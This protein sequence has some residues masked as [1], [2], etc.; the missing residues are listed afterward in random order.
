MPIAIPTAAPHGRDAGAPERELEDDRLPEHDAAPTRRTIRAAVFGFQGLGNLGDEMIL[1]GIEQ[2]LA[3]LPIRV[4]TLF[5]G[6]RLA[7]TPAYR[8][9]SRHTTW[10]LL[11]TP[12]AMRVLARHD[13]FMV[14]GGGLINDYWPGLIPRML[15]WIVAARLCGAR[16]VWMGVGVGPIRRRPWRVLA[17]LAAR[18]SDTVLVRD[19]P[20]ARLLGGPSRRIRVVPDPAL[21]LD[22]PPSRTSEARLGMVVRPPVEDREPY[23]TRL[24]ETLAAFASAARSAGLRPEL[25]MMAP[26]VDAAFAEHVADRIA[27]DGDRPTVEA[28]P[29]APD[30]ALRQ[31]AAL[32]AMVS[33]RLHG[34]F[35]SAVAGVPCVPIGYDIKVAAAA[36]RLGVGDLVVDPDRQDHGDAASALSSAQDPE[37]ISEV[38]RRVSALRGQADG[39]RNVLVR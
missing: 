14:G 3:P 33:V 37:R 25:L 9:A 8:E 16:V 38:A 30:A 27:R 6:P 32:R 19:E 2:L 11:P 23:R 28:L 39:I 36:D 22:S 12:N 26:V 21:F 15:L 17:R 31:V 1:A 7:E 29:T 18:L 35:L 4:T 10:R 24:V 13:L 5:G 34:L 20:S